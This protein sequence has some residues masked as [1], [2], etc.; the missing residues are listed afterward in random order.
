M[1]APVA[2]SVAALIKARHPSWGPLQVGEQL[3]MTC[4]NINA[5]NPGIADL[6]GR[7]R[8]NALRGVTETHSAI[9]AL[10]WSFSDPNGDGRLSQGEAVVMTVSVHN[11]LSPA[12]NPQYTLSSSSP[13]ILVTDA[14]HSGSTLGENA[15]TTLTNAFGFTVAADTPPGTRLDLRLDMTATGYS[16]FQFLPITV[17]PLF[18]THDINRLRVSLTG[19]GGIG[20]IGF[21][22]GLGDEGEGLS[23]DGGPNVLFEGALLLGTGPGNLSDAARQSNERTDFAP[24]LQSPPRAVT[25]GSQAAQEITAGY[26]DSINVTTPLGVRVGLSSWAS[27]TA[28]FDD[29]VVMEFDVQNRTGTAFP[30]L[31]AGLWFDWDID[32]EHFDTNRT[33][34]DSGRRLGYAWDPAPGLPYVGVMSLSGANAGFSAIDN[35]GPGPVIVTGAG[36][37]SKAEKWDVLQ[38]GT[39]VVAA[40]PD[41]IS[42][43]LSSGPYSIPAGGR[44][45]AFFALLAAPNLPALQAAA[46]RALIWFADS[47]TTD[48]GPIPGAR[49]PVVAIG[50]PVPNPFNPSTRV[51][52]VVRTRRE[53]SVDVYDVSGRHVTNLASGVREPGVYPLVWDGRD[54]RQHGVAS[55]VYLIRMRSNGVVQTRRVVLAK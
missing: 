40:G 44:Q 45:S 1:S 46:D 5:Q 50:A 29:F 17:E 43:A 47:V 55:G 26:T 24:M 16:D 15:G 51:D 23:F 35:D 21:P 53:V 52:L 10:Q 22:S 19:T 39:G 14:T 8:V 25:P 34:Y 41:D 3:R 6:L 48:V 54:G 28:P 2:A 27:D 12:V 31:W 11:Y 20:W 4:D 37:F 18:E 13:F 7:G 38:G 49:V 32:E 33:A 36:G 42:N 30:A 9:R